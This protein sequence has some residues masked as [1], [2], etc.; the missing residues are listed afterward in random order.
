M[1]IFNMLLAGVSGDT[2]FKTASLD[3]SAGTE[4]MMFGGVESEPQ[5]YLIVYTYG[6]G[7]RSIDNTSLLITFI[8]ISSDSASYGGVTQGT[9]SSA[10]F[11][12][13][14]NPQSFVSTSYNNNYFTVS[15][16]YSS[17]NPV[18]FFRDSNYTL[19]YR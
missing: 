14:Q 10:V 11:N 8:L 5:E 13:G 15:L 1:S 3:S 7:T 12:T 6:P 18:T 19:F 2:S 17:S 16:T 9:G 4:T